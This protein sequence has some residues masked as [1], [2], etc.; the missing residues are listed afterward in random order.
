[1]GILGLYAGLFDERISRIV[2]QSPPESHRQGPALLNVLRVTDI[3]EAVAAFVRE[4]GI[5][6]V[7]LGRSRRPWYQRWFGRSPLERLLQAV[8]GVD[9]LVVDT[10]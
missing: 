7:V 5:S 1:M 4:Y 8:P 6:H 2:L 9:V 3:P 10:A